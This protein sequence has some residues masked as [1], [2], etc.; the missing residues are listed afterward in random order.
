MA[1]SA[2]RLPVEPGQALADGGVVWKRLEKNSG[3]V[4]FA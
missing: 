3:A 1:S 2:G 4:W